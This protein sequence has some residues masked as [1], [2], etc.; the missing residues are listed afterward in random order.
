MIWD[1]FAVAHSDTSIEY[2]DNPGKRRI[3]EHISTKEAPALRPICDNIPK[4]S[5]LAFA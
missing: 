3:L 4:A 5:T 2:S 1:N